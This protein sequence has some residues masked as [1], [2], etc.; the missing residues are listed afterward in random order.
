MADLTVQ[1]IELGGID[2]VY[3][4][5]DPAGD[6]FVNGGKTFIRLKNE[7]AAMKTVTVQAVNPCSFGY[8]HDVQIS[9]PAGEE[10][11][12]GPFHT[13][14]FNDANDEVQIAY[15]DAASLKIAVF[16]L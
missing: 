5:A 11:Q 14:S 13:Q 10:R 3:E 4:D 1:K 16:Q 6:K 7:G 9:V 15:D 2:P 8:Y 12:A